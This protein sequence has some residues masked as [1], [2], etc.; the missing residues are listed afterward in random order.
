VPT[1]WPSKGVRR[2]SVNSF[3]FG[4][5]NSHVILDDAFHYLQSK[6]LKGNHNTVV[7][8]P[9]DDEHVHVSISSHTSMHQKSLPKLLVLSAND[10]P[11]LGSQ[12]MSHAEFFHHFNT[13]NP[14]HDRFLDNIAYTLNERRTAFSWRSAG[15]VDSQTELGSLE[16]I[17]TKPRK[18]IEDPAVCFIFTGQGAQYPAS[19]LRCLEQFDVFRRRI[20]AA[21]EC[22][23][24]LGCQW[25]VRGELLFHVFKSQ[26]LTNIDE[27]YQTKGL[28][29][30]SRAE[31]S[32]PLSTIVQ[33]A[34]I[35]LLRSFGVFPSVVV[36]HS[37][38]EIAAA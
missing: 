25:S 6:G 14:I 35:D 23:A 18:V 27:L 8:T 24:Q 13:N 21:E 38:G 29:N 15:V 4:G 32:Q 37:S 1:K 22:L 17:L 2:A 7:E 26:T 20:E 3:G 31:Y 9:L 16:T 34:L 11:T 36:G 30:I 28:S 33:I 10:E 5:S 19:V 12:I